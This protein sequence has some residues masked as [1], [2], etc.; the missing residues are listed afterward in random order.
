[1][2]HP[3]WG[4]I[5]IGL[6]IA[7]IGAI[8]LVAPH[9]PWLGKLPGDIA[10]ERPNFRFYFPV[11]AC[12]LLSLLLTAAK[13]PLVKLRLQVF[14]RLG[15]GRDAEVNIDLVD[16]LPVLD[17]FLQRAA[18]DKMPIHVDLAPTGGLGQADD[19]GGQIVDIRVAVADEQYLERCRGSFLAE[20]RGR[21][22]QE[23]G[24][25][26]HDPHEL[27][28][29]CPDHGSLLGSVFQCLGRVY[30]VGVGNAGWEPETVAFKLDQIV[31]WGRSQ[32]FP[33]GGVR[34]LRI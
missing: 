16:G 3:A 22:D 4:L 2:Q 17:V 21:S 10:V 9:I 23:D 20:H 28:S 15:Q 33:C 32:P 1:M 25:T 26:E 19:H 24:R 31:P 14:Q 27:A 13:D 30:N 12:I 7:G 8:W 34:M 29:S 5:A 6:V 11:V 18:A